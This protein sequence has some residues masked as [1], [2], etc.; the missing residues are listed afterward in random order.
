MLEMKK[1]VVLFAVA[2]GLAVAVQAAGPLQIGLS[3]DP[4]QIFGADSE[5][6]GLKLNLPYANNDI[7]RGIDMGFISGGGDFAAIRLNAIN[8]SESRSAGLEVGGVN[9]DSGEVDGLQTALFNHAE[10]MHGLQVGLVNYATHLHGL[11]IGLI[12]YI[13]HSHAAVVLPFVNWDF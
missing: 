11:Q 1:S 5:F 12:N 7:V 2:M 13:R 10:D 8:L 9:W 6:T 3:G 4:L